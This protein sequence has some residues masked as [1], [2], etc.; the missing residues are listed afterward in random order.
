MNRYEENQKLHSFRFGMVVATMRN[1]LRGKNDKPIGALE[2]MGY[3]E[4]ER[5][6]SSGAPVKDNKELAQQE[7]ALR[8]RLMQA[9]Q[10]MVNPGRRRG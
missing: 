2:V 8:F 5:T 6:S 9:A 7:I 4:E 1:L 10:K 3:D